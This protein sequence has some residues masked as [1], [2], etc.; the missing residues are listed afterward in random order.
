MDNVFNKM[1][2]ICL[3]LISS[4]SNNAVALNFVKK[5]Q[6]EGVVWGMTELSS[7]EIFFTLRKGRAGILTT[8]TGDVRWV[9]GLP[10]VVAK[11]QGGLLDVASHS[12]DGN[13]Q[14]LYFTYSKATDKGAVTALARATLQGAKLEDWQDLL[15]TKSASDTGRHFGSRIAFDNQGHV[16]FGV[17]DR[18]HR[19]NG[20]D[21]STHAGTIIRLNLDGSVPSDNPFVNNKDVLPD[22]WSYGH[23]NPQGLCFNKQSNQLWSSEHGPRGGDE[24]NL[25][26]KGSN[27]GW[28]TV[29]HGK[30]YWGPFS[31]GEATSKTGMVDPRHIYIPSIAPGSLLCYEG[32]QIPEFHNRLLLGALKLQHLNTVKIGA[33]QSLADEQR[34]FESQG[35][36]IRSLLQNSKGQLWFADDAGHIYLVTH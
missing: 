23:R 22:I 25:I 10:A 28:A 8:N 35:L 11:G 4:F 15:V 26:E 17:G 18:G 1:L 34:W 33:K 7:N 5:A 16:F 32:N 29:S 3:L 14:W 6:V 24:I 31:V 27:Y 36:R 13:R 21:L 12:V 20:Q 30:E 9:T 19:P 2:F